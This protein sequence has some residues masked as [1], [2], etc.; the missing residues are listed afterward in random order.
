VPAKPRTNAHCASLG[1]A[2][3]TTRGQGQTQEFFLGVATAQE[4]I[5]E[6]ATYKKIHVILKLYR[7]FFEIF[8]EQYVKYNKCFSTLGG[9]QKL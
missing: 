7:G 9:F 1:R 3:A 5:L 8:G 4:K 2:P 6:M